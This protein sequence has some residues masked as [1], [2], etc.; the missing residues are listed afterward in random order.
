M[1]TS[2]DPSI[3]DEFI[4]KSKSRG[5]DD[6]SKRPVIFRIKSK[7]GVDIDD[8]S[9]YG[10]YLCPKNPKCSGIQ[11]EVLLENGTLR[12]VDVKIIEASGFNVY[13]IF[14]EEF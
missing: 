8:I 2:K 12:I 3:A 13:E 4:S 5:L 10:K 6:P 11:Q 14:L 7:N 1:S 9:N